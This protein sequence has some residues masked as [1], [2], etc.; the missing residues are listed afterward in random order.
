MNKYLVSILAL[1]LFMVFGAGCVSDDDGEG[2]ADWDVTESDAGDDA[3]NVDC[4]ESDSCACTDFHGDPEGCEDSGCKPW[5][6]S[7]YDVDKVYDEINDSDKI[8]EDVDDRVVEQHDFCLEEWWI[9][10][11]DTNAVYSYYDEDDDKW[12]VYGSRKILGPEGREEL[13]LVQCSETGDDDVKE[14]CLDCAPY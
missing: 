1:L 11:S 13:N 5:T 10:P 3:N 9:S 12:E 4:T 6:L 2:A 7:E 8:C 14:V